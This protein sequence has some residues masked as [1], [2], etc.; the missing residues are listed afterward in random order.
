MGWRNAMGVGANGCILYDH[1]HVVSCYHPVCRPLFSPQSPPGPGASAVSLLKAFVFLA[2]CQKKGEYIYILTPPKRLARTT[3]RGETA[4]K[5][6]PVCSTHIPKSADQACHPHSEAFQR[7]QQ[8]LSTELAASGTSERRQWQTHARR[9][10]S[11]EPST[12]M[13][14]SVGSR[15]PGTNL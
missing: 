6:R 15:T 11:V 9:F 2:L 5:S 1:H 12:V 7:L 3:P 8:Q 10:P 14:C 4:D 13:I